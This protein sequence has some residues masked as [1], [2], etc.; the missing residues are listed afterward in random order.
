MA[1]KVID[2]QL[3]S[4]QARGR[5]K[6]RSKPYWRTIERGLHLGY[7]R[8]KDKAGTWCARHYIGAQQ[9]EIEAVGI[10]DD[11]SDPD[12]VA[13]LSY[14]D[15]QTKARE[16][17]VKRAH[18]AVGKTGPLTVSDAIDAYLE[19][20]ES[21]NTR[22]AADARSRSRLFIRPKLGHLEIDSLTTEQ[23]QRWLVSIGRAPRNIG[24]TSRQLPVRGGGDGLRM[25]RASANRTLTVLRAALNRVWRA[26]KAGS[27]RAW[28][29]VEPFGN[30]ESA[31]IRYLTIAEAKRLINGCAPT[32]R[33]MVQAALETGAR[34][35][36]LIRLQVHDFNK[37]SGT[38][39]IRRSKSGK[40]RHV[41]LTDDGVALF[42]Q[43]SAGRSGNEPLIRR[44]NGAPF[45]VFDQ[46]LPMQA[47]VKRASI[48]PPI[49][50][51]GLRHTWA[52]LA[53]M[54]GMHMM[55]VARNLGH[56]DT[57]MVEKHYGH[58]APSYI[59]DAIRASAP[60]FGFKPDK[61]VAAI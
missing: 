7:R 54:N 44:A 40:S 47:A 59:V 11:L 55:V 38:V 58:L 53:V 57:R 36:E 10:A 19:Y 3:D 51:H 18:A 49:T 12:G 32:F 61:K 29:A 41:V 42:R 17:M 52:S 39:T 43:L 33:P 24:G 60:R 46:H 25:R 45:R 13:I 26:G 21:K 37:D 50:F 31:R 9:Y 20:L 15:A 23:L 48:S 6:P 34:Y 28:R 2:K 35:G 5:L 8:L 30:V 16:R 14:W 56:V 1:R 27:D 22:S 4:R